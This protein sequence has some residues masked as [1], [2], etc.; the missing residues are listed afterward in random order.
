MLTPRQQQ[1]LTLIVQLYGEL[2]EPIG[3]KTLLKE[4]PLDVSS[5][6]VRNEMKIL[7]DQ[8]YLVKAH[9]SS[10]R[11]PSFEGY[12]LYVNHLIS[13]KQPTNLLEQDSEAFNSLFRE[14]LSDPIQLAQMAANILVELTG[15]AAVVLNRTGEKHYIKEFR[16]VYLNDYS[17]IA[18]LLTDQGHVESQLFNLNYQIPKDAINQVSELINSELNEL[19]LEA[20]SQKLKLTIPMLTQRIVGYQL[21]FSSLIDKTSHTLQSQRYYV[22][23]K[24]NLLDLVDQTSGPNLKELFNL[25][26]G[27]PKMLQLL[28]SRQDGVEVLFDQEILNNQL[29]RL[30]LVTGT[31]KA[32]EL[33]ITVGL[34][35]PTTM[36]FDRIIAIVEKMIDELSRI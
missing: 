6:T 7:E 29:N 11:I 31:Y 13:D 12:H 28:E 15:Y 26:D 20:A 35:G 32:N 19:S 22:V 24:N 36:P 2:E 21:N 10:G 17:V 1:I 23:G 14:R 8:G 27:S 18:T 9:T 25:L 16:L 3:S 5:A 30:S 33:S 34:L 4:S